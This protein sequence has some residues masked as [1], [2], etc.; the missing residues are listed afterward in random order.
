MGKV[1]RKRG[2]QTKVFFV[3]T[4]YLLT[5]IPSFEKFGSVKSSYLCQQLSM[6]MGTTLDAVASQRLLLRL[7]HN[8]T[9]YVSLA[10]LQDLVQN[11]NMT[12][13]IN[14]YSAGI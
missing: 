10:T 4:I 9:G 14:T 3:L 2:I 11:G 6:W 8:N 7:D 1:H 13:T 12:R 5:Q